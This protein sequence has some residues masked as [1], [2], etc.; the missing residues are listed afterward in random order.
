MTLFGY[1]LVELVPHTKGKAR[2]GT[3]SNI[4]HNSDFLH[5]YP[6]TQY[7]DL[8]IISNL[9]TYVGLSYR[10]AFPYNAFPLLSLEESGRKWESS[11]EIGRNRD[12]NTGLGFSASRDTN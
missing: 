5:G 1:Q 4:P 7:H 8:A 2:K 11:P 9:G 3:Q 10:K 6:K 12:S